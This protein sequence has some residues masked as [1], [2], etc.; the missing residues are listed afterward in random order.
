MNPSHL[1]HN[2]NSFTGETTS[3]HKK[4]SLM[5]FTQRGN[6]LDFFFTTRQFILEWKLWPTSERHQWLVLWSY[7]HWKKFSII[8]RALTFLTQNTYTNT[9]DFI[10]W[11]E[12]LLKWL[13]FIIAFQWMGRKQS[14][15]EKLLWRISWWRHQMEIFSDL[16]FRLIDPL[17][18]EFTGHRWIPRTKASDAELWCFLWSAPWING[19]VNKRE[20]CDLRRYRAHHD[21]IV[22][23]K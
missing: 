9:A 6:F 19:W 16:I 2:H 1:Y 13:W 11:R 17:C 22:M 4:Q 23:M 8:K 21:V 20:A 18:G 3:S 5:Q 14:P 15:A 12:L 10:G 7:L